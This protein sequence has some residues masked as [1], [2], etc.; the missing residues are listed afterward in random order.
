[1]QLKKPSRSFPESL[2]VFCVVG[3][4]LALC[5]GLY[6]KRDALCKARFLQWELLTIRNQQIVFLLENKKHPEKLADF[7]EKTSDPFGNS[8]HYDSESDWVS[9]T[10][11]NYR[12]W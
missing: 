6:A 12:E 4:S 2:F 10:T 11:K 3:V 7:T 9:T 8:Y 5:L 1:M